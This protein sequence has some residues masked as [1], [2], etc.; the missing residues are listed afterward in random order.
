MLLVVLLA[1][2]LTG[3]GESAQRSSDSGTGDEA[4]TKLDPIK[5]T[6]FLKEGTYSEFVEE[7]P[8]HKYIRENLGVDIE[9]I[10]AQG[11]A[12]QRLEL[13]LVS[14][15]YPD[16]I[17]IK[18]GDLN[19]AYVNNGHIVKLDA[20]LQQYAPHLKEIV[21]RTQS[22]YSKFAEPGHW[23]I[24]GGFGYSEEYPLIEPMIGI[25]YDLWKEQGYPKLETL[26]D[27]YAFAK[28]AQDAHPEVDGKKA[29][30]FS[31]WFGDWGYWAYHAMY[32]LGGVTGWYGPHD[33]NQRA[34][35]TW[36]PFSD[37][38]IQIARFL[39]RAVREGYA[40]PEGAVQN[41][42]QYMTK[43]N[44]GRI[45]V[46]YYGGDWMDGVANRSRISAGYPE[47]RLIPYPWLKLDGYEGEPLTGQYF[48][49][50]AGFHLY[51]TKNAKD[52]EEIVRRLSWLWTDEGNVLT[53]MGIEG[54]HWDY[55]AD[56]FRKPRPELIELVKHDPNWQHITGIGKYRFVTAGYV[57]GL[58]AK[59]DAYN[60]QENRYYLEGSYDDVDR[61]IL[62]VLGVS[63]YSELA[64]VG[65]TRVDW[66]FRNIEEF[67]PGS[68]EAETY[69]RMKD[70][71]DE[72]LP[73]LYLAQS[74]EEFDQLLQQFQ[75]ENIAI[76]Y[77]AIEDLINARIRISW[78]KH[79]DFIEQY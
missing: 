38:F 17:A 20:Y 59:G 76:G 16:A 71:V 35:F 23:S 67:A 54:V 32:R 5:F 19:E 3:C 30:A 34:H 70:T 1:V 75:E 40:D 78:E 56:G 73:R 66:W 26:T 36:V 4:N 21:E 9:I 63:S 14:G 48:V 15:N 42:E 29:Y 44:E 72:Y 39:N 68:Q 28:Q 41:H 8:I 12:D 52:P 10:H 7:D 50:G 46:N 27:L 24:P 47:Q 25:R 65:K 49:H 57:D 77:Q 79:K 6:V 74:E 13:M 55:D 53:G 64:K 43:L 18:P 51:I 33:Y 11:S 62:D 37:E 45:Y 2:S 61:E 31:A 69:Q 60:I 22:D 58:D